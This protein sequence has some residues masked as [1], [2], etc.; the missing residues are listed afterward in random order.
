MDQ[1]EK[2]DLREKKKPL[3]GFT[4]IEIMV[5]V[6]IIGMLSALVGVAVIDRFEKAK[7]QAAKAQISNFMSALD[8]YYLDNSR[9][10]TTEQGLKALVQKPGSSPQPPNYPLN[11]Y[12]NSQS[13]PL[14]KW[15]GEYI[16]FCPGANNQPFTI[17]S[18]GADGMAGG[19][20]KNAD[21]Q[22][23]NLGGN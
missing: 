12:L 4:L 2:R 5:V 9:Y 18:Y 11:G 21:I 1:A 15:G 6:M 20:D 7:R 14:D 23:W 13:I 3:A 22:S 17:E 19:E 16:Y 8:N 10:P